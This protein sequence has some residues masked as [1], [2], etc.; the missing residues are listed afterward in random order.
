VDAPKRL[1]SMSDEE[2]ADFQRWD[3]EVAEHY[4]VTIRPPVSGE[5][6]T[7]AGRALAAE[8]PVLLRDRLAG[9]HVLERILA[10]ESE[11][12]AT[13]PSL[14][15]ETVAR[16]AHDSWPK[17]GCTAA[18]HDHNWGPDSFYGDFAAGLLSRL[19]SKEER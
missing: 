13:P 12:R 19:T 8:F 16:A 6:R 9:E 18:I 10:I 1:P 14:D 5:P 7:E 4:G 17:P 2:W 11:A 15:V 3:R